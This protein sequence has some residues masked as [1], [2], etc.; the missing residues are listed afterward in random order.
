MISMNYAAQAAENQGD[1]MRLGLIPLMRDIYSYSNLEPLTK[2]TRSSR[3]T[4]FKD[5]LPWKISQMITNFIPSNT[6]MV[7]R[8][9]MKWGIPL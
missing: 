4:E 3:N 5:I 8:N 6:R 2:F 7:I 9:A 1:P